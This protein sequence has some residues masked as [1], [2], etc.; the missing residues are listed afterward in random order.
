MA[1]AK[2]A[3][4]R[5]IPSIARGVM[6]A[7]SHCAWKE[8][9][10][11]PTPQVCRRA[12]RQRKATTSLRHAE[13]RSLEPQMRVRSCPFKRRCWLRRWKSDNSEGAEFGGFTGDRPGGAPAP[14]PGPRKV[15]PRPHPKGS[16]SELCGQQHNSEYDPFQIMAR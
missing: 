6:L 2:D 11:L 10:G 3:R 9:T 4:S 16:Y 15:R 14:R 12:D 8:T 7:L 13:Y 1:Q 5:F